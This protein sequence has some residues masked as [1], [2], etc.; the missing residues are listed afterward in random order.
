MANKKRNNDLRQ[1]SQRKSKEKQYETATK[2]MF[3]YPIIAV[4]ISVII[5]LLFFTVFADIYERVAQ[6]QETSVSGW[7]FVRSGFTHLS[8]GTYISPDLNKIDK[9]EG[10]VEPF[11]DFATEWCESVA[12]LSVATVL[13]VAIGIV[14][15]VVT[16]FTRKHL[17]NALSAVISLVSAILLIVIYAKC[18]DMNNATIISDY[19]QNPN[20]IIRSNVIF[21]ALFA[22]GGCAVSGFATFKYFKAK[23]L[24]K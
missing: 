10:L 4:V 3:I 8:E 19:C 15:Q 7:A 2:H 23:S 14:A 12:Q 22:F 16:F 9:Y 11:Y 6:V 5:L 20:C 21:P 1:A 24:L 17:L 13:I 18:L